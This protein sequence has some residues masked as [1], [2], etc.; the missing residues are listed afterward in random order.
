MA[1]PGHVR[2]TSLTCPT[3]AVGE[4]ADGAEAWE[5]ELQA[6]LAKL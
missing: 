3:Q 4:A 1:C 2:D 5:A 6:E